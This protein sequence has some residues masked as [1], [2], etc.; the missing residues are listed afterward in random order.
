[1]RVACECACRRF[2]HHAAICPRKVI[3]SNSQNPGDGG[4]GAGAA[5]AVV[6]LESGLEDER[7]GENRTMSSPSP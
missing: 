7:S 6:A 3:T 1:M 5:A 2:S 4:D